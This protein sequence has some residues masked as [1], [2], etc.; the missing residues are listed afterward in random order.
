MSDRSIQL[1]EDLSNSFGPSGFERDAAKVLKAYVEPFS[2]EITTDKLGSLLF[3]KRG[4]ADAPVIFLPG[5]IDEVGFVV[6]GIGKEGFLSFNQVGGWFDQVLL[7][8]RV[9]VR[10]SKGILPGVVAAKPPHLLGPEERDKVV[11][12][13]KMFIDI[14]A[15]NEDEAKHMGVRVGDPVVPDSRFSV[16]TKPVF[17][18]GEK[19]GEMKLAVGKGFD[20]RIGAFVAAEVV[21]TLREENI[22]HPNTVVGG[23]TVQE[24]VGLRGA[25]TSAWMVKPDVCLT[26][27][28]DISGD[29]PGI[30]PHKALTKMG[31]GPSVLTFDGSMIPNQPLKDLVI[32]T[33][34]EAGIPCQ[35]SQMSRGGT[36]A[37]VIHITYAGC[38]SVVLGVPTRHIHSHVGILSLEDAENCVKLVVEVI[39]RLDADRV[40]GL[41]AL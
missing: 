41:T 33:A 22:D 19:K 38:P 8:Q 35:L 18:D 21:R 9:L 12:K 30:E 14:G 10:T 15:S 16:A 5:H 13:D 20:D 24:E 36:D 28:V 23:G 6:S 1:L 40:A 7:S 34:E 3:T 32:D 2:D 17:E 37:G 29:V 27:E 26:L 39:K 31:K 11:K 25:R 4:A